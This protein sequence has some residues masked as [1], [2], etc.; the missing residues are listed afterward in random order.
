MSKRL[1][2]FFICVLLP[3]SATFAAQE[4]STSKS[5][6]NSK[7]AKKNSEAYS[8]STAAKTQFMRESGYRNGRPGYVV[9]YRKPLACGGADDISNLQWLTI[10]E[11][12]AKEKTQRKGCK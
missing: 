2:A 7:A 4:G 6:T 9:A 12:K 3:V 10:A 1:V 5:E 11:A 8:A